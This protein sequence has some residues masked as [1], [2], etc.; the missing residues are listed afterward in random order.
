MVKVVEKRAMIKKETIGMRLIYGDEAE[1]FE[2][3]FDNE[4][5]RIYRIVE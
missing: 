4:R 5:V 2:K 3:V 1:G